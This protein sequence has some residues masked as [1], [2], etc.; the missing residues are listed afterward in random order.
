MLKDRGGITFYEGD[1]AAE[2]EVDHRQELVSVKALAL[3]ILLTCLMLA[4]AT[5]GSR[6]YDAYVHTANATINN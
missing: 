2:V 1:Y 6:V 3:I 4:G 5:M